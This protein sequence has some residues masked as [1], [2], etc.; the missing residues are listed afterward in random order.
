MLDG[1]SC[2]LRLGSP[3]PEACWGSWLGNRFP[4]MEVAAVWK[5][6]EGEGVQRGRPLSGAPRS[7]SHLVIPSGSLGA[8]FS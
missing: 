4:H 5:D 7:S 1:S 3:L 2:M 8:A 6:G